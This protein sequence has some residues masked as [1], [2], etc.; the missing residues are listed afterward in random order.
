[1]S[2]CPEIQLLAVFGFALGLLVHCILHFAIKKHISPEYRQILENS[3]VK[4]IQFDYPG[5]IPV[6]HLTASG[7]IYK[8]I[9]LFSAV[10]FITSASYIGY[11]NGSEQFCVQKIQL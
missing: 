10:V 1:M 5:F 6:K 2:E 8:W 11:L 7:R 4:A 3:K 9:A